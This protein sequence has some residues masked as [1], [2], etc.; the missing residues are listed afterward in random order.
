M[1]AQ[2]SPDT[3]LHQLLTMTASAARWTQLEEPSEWQPE[4]AVVHSEYLYHVRT[5]SPFL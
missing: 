5:V 4:Q 1:L 2:I 3:V